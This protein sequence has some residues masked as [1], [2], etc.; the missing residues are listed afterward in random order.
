MTIFFRK[1]GFKDED[2]Q[3]VNAVKDDY[4]KNVVKKEDHTLSYHLEMWGK[5][6]DKILG[7]LHDFCIWMR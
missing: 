3:I 2:L 5:S 4:F 7:E 6:S 1:N